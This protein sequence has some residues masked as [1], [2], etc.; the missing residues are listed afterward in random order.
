MAVLQAFYEFNVT[1]CLIWAVIVLIATD[2]LVQGY[3]KV[4]KSVAKS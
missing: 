4:S 3:L 1:E 2:L